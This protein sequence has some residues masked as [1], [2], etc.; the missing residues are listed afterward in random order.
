MSARH[1]HPI[2]MLVMQQNEVG[3]WAS[4]CSFAKLLNF[5]SQFLPAMLA[6]LSISEKGVSDVKTLTHCIRGLFLIRLSII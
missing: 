4:A 3:I 2:I 5:Y 6:T 1:L